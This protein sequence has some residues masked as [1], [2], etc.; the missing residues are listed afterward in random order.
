MRRRTLSFLTLFAAA[1]AAGCSDSITGPAPAPVDAPRLGVVSATGGPASLVI[2]AADATECGG[3]TDVTL[4]VSGRDEPRPLDIAVLMDASWGIGSTNFTLMKQ[5]ISAMIDSIGVSAA[6]N[7][8]TII[9]FAGTAT[10]WHPF[11]S[12]QTNSALKA[13][14]SARPYTGGTSYMRSAV[15]LAINQWDAHGHSDA[16]RVMVLITDGNPNP[17]STQEPCAL[18]SQLASRGVHTL[19]FGLGT[20]WTPSVVQCLVSDASSQIHQPAQLDRMSAA[21]RGLIE[22]R[23]AVRNVIASATVGEGFVIEGSPSAE[24]G[25]VAVNGST[26]T[27]TIAEL[28][29]APRTLTVSV[30]PVNA[31]GASAQLIAGGSLTYTSGGATTTQSLGGLAVD[32]G[33]CDDTP[34]EIVADVTGTMGREGWYVSDVSIAWSVNDPESQVSMTGCEPGLVKDDTGE[35]AFDCAANS[36]GGAASQRRS[37]RRD[38]TKPSLLL[39][40]DRARYLLSDRV[41]I[42]CAADDA[43][44]GLESV[45]CPESSVPA[46][47]LGAGRHTILAR[48]SDVAG[49]E[50]E[51]AVDITV[52]ANHDALCGLTREWVSDAGSASMLC[53]MIER[54]K[55]LQGR[56]R[57][58]RAHMKLYVA[59][60]RRLPGSVIT[61][62]HREA[63]IQI[64]GQL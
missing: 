38:A 41:V 4:S 64:A 57:A 13:T 3:V 52:E 58:S 20:N 21:L 48:A 11:A 55:R 5:R 2:S 60:V 29:A 28:G 62:E 56:G 53:K 14:V 42:Q 46:W 51:A 15:Q 36:L 27:W 49:N 30:R 44:S 6:G 7:H 61:H 9:Q 33:S 32:V 43:M 18:A 37:V 19:I 63:L 59:A 54:A 50:I 47:T 26:L 8:M 22:Q 40:A 35:R 45:R 1:F 12:P 10:A 23:S 17:I 25:K 34:P 39:R 31:S 24:S 16:R